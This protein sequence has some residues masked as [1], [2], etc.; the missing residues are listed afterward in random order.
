MTV[1]F[2]HKFS[3][4]TVHVRI[5]RHGAHQVRAW[6]VRISQVA[7]CTPFLCCSRF[8]PIAFNLSNTKSSL[9]LLFVPDCPFRHLSQSDRTQR[10][11]RYSV[12]EL[13]N[14]GNMLYLISRIKVRLVLI[15]DIVEQSDWHKYAIW[16]IILYVIC[17]RIQSSG[18]SEDLCYLGWYGIRRIQEICVT[19]DDPESDAYQI[20]LSSQTREYGNLCSLCHTRREI[21]RYKTELSDVGSVCSER[22]L[23]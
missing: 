3:T 7:S 8:S 20:S 17:Q 15:A 10:D 23:I 22:R 16:V 6:L 13:R 5:P 4:V 14:F 18:Y 21:K 2:P 11:H 9:Q 19:S 1:Q 12:T